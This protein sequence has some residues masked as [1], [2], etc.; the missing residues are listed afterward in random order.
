[1]NLKN[2]ARR[3]YAHIPDGTLKNRLA[4]A[5]YR[6]MYGAA[7]AECAWR[8]G[9]F[10]VRTPD[11]T[12]VRSVCAYDPAPLAR[13]FADFA[14][15]PDDVAMDVGGNVGAVAAWLS[16]RVGPGGRVIAFEPDAVNREILLRNLAL[17][18]ATNAE[19]IPRGAWEFD[20][21]LDFHAGGTYTSSFQSTD[22]I[23]RNPDRYRIERIPVSAI[24][25]E[26]ARLGL[27]RLDLI[28]M[29]IEG[30]EGPALR[31]AMTTLRRFRPNVVVETHRVCGVLT[32]DE[33]L[34]ALRAAGYDEPRIQ[35]DDETPAVFAAG[36]RG[37]F[38]PAPIAD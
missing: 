24:D 34:D 38:A 7:L 12:A 26:V 13:D 19:I 1:M 33:V 27:T 10:V 11:G 30:S 35:P 8:G 15:G 32:L 5:A 9:E 28:K 22:Y 3:V 23:E 18:G 6:R 36:L 2:L 25:T 20:G 29:D 14:P 16:A 21:E 31:G 37:T 17:N 4:A